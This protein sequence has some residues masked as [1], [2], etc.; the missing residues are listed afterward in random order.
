MDLGRLGRGEQIAGASAV[1]LLIIALFF[2]W[3]SVGPVGIG[4]F[5]AAGFLRDLVM[6][7]A[8]A[9]GIGLAVI[10]A[11]AQSIN[12]P[13]AP[14]AIAAG[15]AILNTILILIWV[16]DPPGGGLVDRSIGLFLGLIAS[17][18]IA[19]G[20]WLAMQDEGTS[21][22]GEADRFRDTSGGEGSRREASRG[23]GPGGGPS[24]GS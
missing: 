18:G 3:F 16:I 15:I 7:L 4:G 21:F 5:E 2:S 13:V 23:E 11:S 6:F 22:T 20:A 1:A 12:S 14:S 10:A 17:G 24:A 19:Y 9:A 8:I